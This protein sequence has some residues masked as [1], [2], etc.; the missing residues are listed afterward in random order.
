M[1]SHRRDDVVKAAAP[2]RLTAAGVAFLCVLAGCSRSDGQASPVP[3]EPA[4][5]TASESA[6]TEAATP[7]DYSTLLITTEDIDSSEPFTAEPPIL[8]PNGDAGVSGRFF[9]EDSS[10]IGSTI[11]VLADPVEAARVLELTRNGISNVSGR[12]EPSPIGTNGSVIAGTSLDQITGIT[13]LT[14]SEQN[15]VVTLEFDSPYGKLEGLPTE[16]IDSV[17]RRQLEILKAKLPEIAPP[18][19]LPV[20]ATIGGKPVDV[21]GPVVCKYW[22]G[23][24]TITAGNSVLKIVVE[25]E[26]DASVVHR[27]ELADVD[28]VYLSSPERTATATRDGNT[29]TVIGTASGESDTTPPKQV[30]EPFDISLTCP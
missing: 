5:G 13:M 2:I 14:F 20:A 18:A 1:G 24:S 6:T 16:L 28:D 23:R 29:Y 25:L 17:A 26:P 11:R 27:V 7:A 19:P 22:N 15:A 21:R 8:N 4:S 30:T 3:S 12:R 10:M 9:A